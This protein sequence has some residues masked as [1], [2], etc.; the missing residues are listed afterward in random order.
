MLWSH[1]TDEVPDL[2]SS[3]ATYTPFGPKEDDYLEYQKLFWIRKNIE[4]LNQDV[5]DEFSVCLG[6]IYGWL[7]NAVDMRIENVEQRRAE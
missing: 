4:G 5:I 6:K 1:N 3:M 7:R 2:W